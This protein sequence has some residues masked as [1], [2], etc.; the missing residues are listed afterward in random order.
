MALWILLTFLL[1]SWAI[2][3]NTQAAIKNLSA[4]INSS[5]LRL[6]SPG[7]ISM[8]LVFGGIAGGFSGAA[9]IDFFLLFLVTLFNLVRLRWACNRLKLSFSDYLRQIAEPSF[10]GWLTGL[11]FVLVLLAGCRIISSQRELDIQEQKK[12]A[13]IAWCFL[14]QVICWSELYSIKLNPTTWAAAVLGMVLSLL[15]PLVLAG[16]VSIAPLFVAGSGIYIF[17]FYHKIFQGK[18]FYGSFQDP[19][20]RRLALRDG[21]LLGVII[22]GIFLIGQ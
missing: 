6:G 10:N 14:I 5:A 22:T 17:V 13:L 4:G 2:F 9:V 19:K 7:Q 20:V 8:I 12:N 16:K 21:F 11:A 3:R 15:A 1:G 18:S